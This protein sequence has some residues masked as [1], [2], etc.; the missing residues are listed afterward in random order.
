M[1]KRWTILEPPPQSFFDS[2]P[3][4]SR[5]VLTL[6]YNRGIRTQKAIDEFLT[7]EYS[8]DVHDPF[9][10]Q[11]MQKTV[12]RLFL[13]ITQNEHITIHG[14][15]DADGVSASV[16][17]TDTLTALGAKHV[18]VYLPHR[19]TDGYGL[20]KNTINF[21]HQKGTNIIITCD[22]G[23]SNA[24]EVAHARTKN[25]DVII[26]DHHSVPEIL[27]EAFSI[28]HPKV[29]DEPYPCKNL[30]GGAV[31]FKL[32]QG[33]LHT[34]KK[35]N[36]VLP[37][38][39]THDGFEKWLL[40]MV[41]VASVADMVPLLEETRTL[42]KYGL[43]VLNKTRRLGLKKLYI[44]TSLSDPDGTL[45]NEIGTETIGFR[46]APQI[47]AAGRLGHANTA[48]ELL[49][50]KKGTDAIDL[51]F[52][53]N[54]QNNERRA[55]TMQY[56]EEAE[57]QIAN[58]TKDLPVIFVYSDN[59]NTGIIGLIAGR[60]KEKYQKPTIAMAPKKGEITGSGRSIDGFNLIEALQENPEFFAKFG[61][62][63]MAC[64]FSLAEPNIKEAMQEA[65]CNTYTKKTKNIDM[66]PTL[67]IDKEITLEE[68]TWNALE[69]IEQCKPF[70]QNNPKPLFVAKGVTVVKVDKMGKDKSH[71]RL[72]LTHTTNVI[73]KAVGWQMC[74]PLAEK[75]WGTLL[76][77]NDKI[78]IVFDIG[79]NEWNGNREIQ[80]TLKD[81]HKI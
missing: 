68:V 58:Q 10:F 42:T 44:E 49:V 78:D 6:L 48:Y 53:L 39:E 28:I 52:A 56:V 54:E 25:M 36:D 14:D 11:D 55:L 31:A 19:E 60:I 2:N 29:P 74:G 62:H 63:P 32:A 12:D 47:N 65:L 9:L 21:L 37:N 17:L 46:I 75:D 34:H 35:D 18:D 69:A 71:I 64:G 80:I 50:A 1:E 43:M 5:L 67:S 20:N 40:D 45:R 13:A 59:W 30:A 41:A 76:S 66:A 81:I 61:G 8:N 70:G 77:P 4:Q 16:I 27:P 7:P 51:A 15:Y 33:L 23:I 26:T 38:G 24:A 79:I 73:K 72:Q 22:C 57:N 3:E